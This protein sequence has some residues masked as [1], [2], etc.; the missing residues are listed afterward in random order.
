MARRAVNRLSGRM[1]ADLFHS[2][3]A[4]VGCVCRVLPT[5]YFNGDSE[6][7]NR[8]TARRAVRPSTEAADCGLVRVRTD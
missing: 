8:A 4:G 3:R 2:L 5:D 6:L 7:Y 1:P